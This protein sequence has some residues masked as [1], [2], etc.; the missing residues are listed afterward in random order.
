MVKHANPN[1]DDFSPDLSKRIGGNHHMN[2]FITKL[3]I[4]GIIKCLYLPTSHKGS[5]NVGVSN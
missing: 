5:I 2:W 3:N 1:L 4:V